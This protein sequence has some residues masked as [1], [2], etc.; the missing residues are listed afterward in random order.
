MVAISRQGPRRLARPCPC[1]C[2]ASRE[3]VNCFPGECV[4]DSYKLGVQ[5]A[6]TP[7]PVPGV[8]LSP[9]IEL[10]VPPWCLRR[11]GVGFPE[12]LDLLGSD[13]RGPASTHLQVP[14]VEGLLEDVG[15]ICPSRQSPHVGQVAAE[16]AHGLDDEH[17]PLGPA[18][19][20]LDA[21]ARL[22]KG[23]QS[24]DADTAPWPALTS[25]GVLSP[26]PWPLRAH[27]QACPCS[28]FS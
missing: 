27:Q 20:L 8:A 25:G 9:P 13:P 21:V 26:G 10:T 18:G 28:V 7:E 4:R 1:K 15:S 16:A 3:G 11:W 23:T 24:G 5:A 12:T 14:D 22:H 17:A 19:R 6:G 2:R